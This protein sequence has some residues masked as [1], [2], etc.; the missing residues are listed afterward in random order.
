MVV[1]ADAVSDVAVKSAR[2]MNAAAAASLAAAL[3]E[4][5]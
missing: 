5:M 2:H 1:D 4:S 3:K